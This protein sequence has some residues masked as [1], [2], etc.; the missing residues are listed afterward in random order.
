MTIPNDGLCRAVL[1]EMASFK[2]QLPAFEK[3]FL[4]SN[5]RREFFT[6]KQKQTVRLFIQRYEL[7]CAKGYK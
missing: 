1:D 3:D 2:E 7:H 6:D 5:E 4:R